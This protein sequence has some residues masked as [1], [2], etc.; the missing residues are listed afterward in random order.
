MRLIELR[1]PK[2]SFS[3]R[4]LNYYMLKSFIRSSIL[5]LFCCFLLSCE[6]VILDIVPVLQIEQDLSIAGAGDIKYFTFLSDQVG[7]AASDGAA[8]YK[9][10]DGGKTWTRL[11]VA[12]KGTCKGLE[13][14]DTQHG[15][16][17]INQTVYVTSNGGNSWTTKTTSDFIGITKEG[18][19]VIGQNCSYNMHCVY[20]TTNKGQSFQLLG[21]LGLQGDFG[22]AKVTG[23]KLYLIP[24]KVFSEDTFN[25]IDVK[26][27]IK[28]QVAFGNLV[29][30]E[31]PTDILVNDNMGLMVGYPGLIM[32]RQEDF[33]ATKSFYLKDHVL[34][35]KDYLSVDGFDDLAV[36]VGFKVISV[37]VD[38]GEGE[39]WNELIG[40]QGTS[41]SQTFYKV[42]FAGPN[43]FYISGENGLLWKA[44]I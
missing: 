3:Q 27:K 30:Y 2:H 29:Y 26:T 9:T 13:F 10:T 15:M 17:L 42:K 40:T 38:F 21:N 23:N 33:T 20:T 32:Q 39:N 34:S 41:F 1:C 25:G 7:Y 36:A 44:K 37:N 18:V 6:K 11:I 16:C 31:A 28:E 12:S 24:E 35:K 14:F 5:S 43:S 22:F 8:V 4:L 19:G